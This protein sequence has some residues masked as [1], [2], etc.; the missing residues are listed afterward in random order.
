[1]FTCLLTLFP[2]NPPIS[3]LEKVDFIMLIYRTDLFWWGYSHY[4]GILKLLKQ[5]ACIFRF[6]SEG[7]MSA[8]WRGAEADNQPLIS[9][10]L[11]CLNT[12]S[13]PLS[14]CPHLRRAGGGRGGQTCG[15][16]RACIRGSSFSLVGWLLI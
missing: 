3:F 10:E 14:R 9:E 8:G 7:Q 2:S 4:L 15:Y 16:F 1:M 11:E 12:P 6:L 13:L 5:R